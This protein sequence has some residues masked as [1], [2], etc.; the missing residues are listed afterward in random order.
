MSNEA[1]DPVV[2]AAADKLRAL[3]TPSAPP[4]AVTPPAAPPVNA[5]VTPPAGEAPK[6][7]ER[8]DDGKFKKREMSEAE[9]GLLSA[10]RAEREK[11]KGLES[12]LSAM[13]AEIA[14]LKA[15]KPSATASHRDDLLKKAP[16]ETQKFWGEVADPVVR[17][18]VAEEVAK[19]LQKYQP[20]LEA[21]E[22]RRAQEATTQAFTA[23]LVDFAEEMALEGIAFDPA[24]LVDKIRAFETEHDISLGSTNRRK[25]ENALRLLEDAGAARKSPE[26][27]AAAKA[28]QEA[29]A[30]AR[31][32]GVAPS[33]T[34]TPP[35]PDQRA[36]LQATVKDLAKKGDYRAIG[37]ILHDRIK[38]RPN[39][40][41]PLGR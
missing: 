39:Y 13:Q 31:A 3:R 26:L 21:V 14:A 20:A 28:K 4:A 18:T 36:T 33:T 35:P 27:E 8:G 16:E 9:K 25:F 22:T 29:E 15:S 19:L 6:A 41:H 10:A 23:D 24:S 2:K 38:S 5:P 7:P 40:S 34:T 12:T 37:N 32:G 1:S 17:D 30:K 11:R